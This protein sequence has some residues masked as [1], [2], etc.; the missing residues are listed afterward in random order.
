MIEFP[1]TLIE[2]TCGLGIETMLPAVLGRRVRFGRMLA[3][4]RMYRRM[5]ACKFFTSGLPD[6]L[7]ADLSRSARAFAYFLEAAEDAAK[8]TSLSE[9][10]FDA[11]ACGDSDAEQAIARHSRSSWNEGEEYEDDF[12]YVWFLMSRFT[13]LAPPE[14][15]DSILTRW[16]RALEGGEDPRLELC[17]AIMVRDQK[18]FDTSLAQIIADQERKLSEKART[19]QLSPDDAPTLAKLW[20]EL[21]AL[22]QLA[23]RTGLGTNEQFDLAPSGVRHPDRAALP[24]PDAWQSI[25]SYQELG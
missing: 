19:D 20:V 1:L 23:E 13:L 25:K 16:K 21:L 18:L 8:L 10:F 24:P 7:F 12:L 15:L 9:P 22:L 17:R 4:C 6:Q 3:F 5:G 11:V 14:T 2:K